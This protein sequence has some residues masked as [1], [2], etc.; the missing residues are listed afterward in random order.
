MNK[1]NH[2]LLDHLFYLLLSDL[3]QYKEKSLKIDG[4][5]HVSDYNIQDYISFKH[6]LSFFS[7]VLMPLQNAESDIQIET[8]LNELESGDFGDDVNKSCSIGAFKF[9]FTLFL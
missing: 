9:S 2:R 1:K 6:G 3:F 5:L 8:C 7:P 4:S